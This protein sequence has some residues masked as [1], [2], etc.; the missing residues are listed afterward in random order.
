M[1]YIGIE[2]TELQYISD[3]KK[4]IKKLQSLNLIMEYKPFH[5]G[6]HIICY[7][8]DVMIIKKL[9]YKNICCKLLFHVYPYT[10]INY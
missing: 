2:P 7:V 1:N 3:L 10:K 5:R 9:I 6:V 8:K 4:N